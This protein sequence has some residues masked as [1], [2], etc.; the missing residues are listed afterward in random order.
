MQESHSNAT[1]QPGYGAISCP[2]A[3]WTVCPVGATGKLHF[4]VEDGRI[5]ADATVR[6]VR[7][8]SGLGLKFKTVRSED[9]AR[10]ATMIKRA[11]RTTEIVPKPNIR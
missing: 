3:E 1:A 8:G 6:Y 11:N 4:L 5:M 9:Q 10:F 2:E 7:A